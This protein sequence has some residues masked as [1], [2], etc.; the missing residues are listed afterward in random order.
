MSTDLTS[1]LPVEPGVFGPRQRDDLVAFY[2]RHGFVVVRDLFPLELMAAME[3]ECIAAQQQVIAGELP[4]RH[5]STVFLDEAAKAERF[6]NYV[7]YVN[8]LSPATLTAATDPFL[9]EVIR[10]LI[11]PSCWLNDTSR[12]GVVY[13]DCD[14]AR[15]PVTP[16]SAGT[17]TGRRR[18][19]W[20][21][22]RP[23]RSRSTSTAPARPTASSES[24]PEVTGG[25][26]RRPIGTSTTLRS[27]T[28]PGP[29]AA[30]PPCRPHL[31]CRWDS[32]GSEVRSPF[33]PSPATSSC[34]TPTCGTPPRG[35]RTT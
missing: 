23:L 19:T 12:A 30:T 25:P 17:R 7:E 28:T 27:R 2:R 11:G 1:T 32:R 24:C 26:P 4:D 6:A 22:G 5:G 18:R 8:E 20:T 21:S 10:E 16:G 33:T 13:Q 3:A 15:S 14:R 9:V 35:P 31:R 34:T 29:P